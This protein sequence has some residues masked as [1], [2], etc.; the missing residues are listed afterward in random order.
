M[1]VQVIQGHITDRAGIRDAF[2]QWRDR[3]APGAEG[4][5]GMTAGITADDELVA[6][7]RFES[8]E[9]AQRNSHRAEQHQ[10]WME[11]SKLFAGDATFH[12]CTD[13]ETLLDSGSDDAG[14][15][16]VIQGR[17]RNPEQL[18][19][20]NR[21]SEPV[22]REYRPDIIGGISAY[23]DSD[24]VTQF[25]YFTSEA[26]ARENERKPMPPEMAEAYGTEQDLFTDL[27]YFDLT[28]PW[29]WLFSPSR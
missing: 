23:H 1:F 21:Q 16:Q 8:T 15:V 29:L 4:W 28:S 20:V 5:L 22:L 19:Q 3:L 2:E 13:V 17:T 11:T 9:L 14:F 24:W 12:D 26:Q 7:A 25:V 27:R 6:L 10:W 18:K